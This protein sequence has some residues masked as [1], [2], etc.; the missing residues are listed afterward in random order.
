MRDLVGPL[1]SP[2]GFF[3]LD[4]LLTVLGLVEFGKEKSQSLEGRLPLVRVFEGEEMLT[5]Y[6]V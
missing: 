5:W 2:E 4:E 6:D 3:V 1:L